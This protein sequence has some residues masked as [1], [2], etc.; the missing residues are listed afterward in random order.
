MNDQLVSGKVL[1]QRRELYQLL[2]KVMGRV[3]LSP[4]VEEVAQAPVNDERII[5]RVHHNFSGLA[6]NTTQPLA[7]QIGFKGSR[8]SFN[9]L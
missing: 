7:N 1:A 4:A 3:N 8:Q 6:G 5:E 2:F 9:A